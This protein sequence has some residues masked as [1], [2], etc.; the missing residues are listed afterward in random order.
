M[1]NEDA[2]ENILVSYYHETSQGP[3]IRISTESL[4]MIALIKGILEGL[5]KKRYRV[6]QFQDIEHMCFQGLTALTL[7]VIDGNREPKKILECIKGNPP[8]SE[9]CWSR[10]SEGWDDDA[11]WI[12]GIIKANRPGH[13]YFAGERNDD[14]L[15]IIA[16][17]EGY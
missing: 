13:Q 12:D 5:S 11:W 7:Q 8:H 4:K 3:V 15:I 17:R 9:F 2:G 14:A 16:Y 10:T 1:S 6:I